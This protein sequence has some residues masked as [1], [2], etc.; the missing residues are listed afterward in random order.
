MNHGQELAGT[1]QTARR[2]L[3]AKAVLPNAGKPS[4]RISI[5]SS[6][7]PPTHSSS[8]CKESVGILEHRTPVFHGCVRTGAKDEDE[9]DHCSKIEESRFPSEPELKSS[10][11]SFSLEKGK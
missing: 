7:L 6:P 5:A 1:E 8:S 9:K 11:S 10:K 4:N 3:L 2:E